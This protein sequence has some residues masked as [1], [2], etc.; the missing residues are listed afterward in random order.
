MHDSTQPQL[1][2]WFRAEICWG[3]AGAKGQ[4]VEPEIPVQHLPEPWLAV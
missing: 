3:V 2:H 4:G 1:C